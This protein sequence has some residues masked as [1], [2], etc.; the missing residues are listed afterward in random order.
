M[1]DLSNSDELAHYMA[2]LEEKRAEVWRG[3]QEKFRSLLSKAVENL[4]QA[5][6]S[7][8]L[9]ASIE[10]LKAVG[11]YGDGTMN[12]IGEQDPEKLIHQ[13]AESQGDGEGVLRN[14]LLAM[15][16]NLDNAAWRH[17]LAEME[18]EIRRAYLDGCIGVSTRPARGHTRMFRTATRAERRYPP[19]PTAPDHT[20]RLVTPRTILWRKRRV[21]SQC[22]RGKL[23]PLGSTPSSSTTRSRR[24]ALCCGGS[25]G[26]S[27]AEP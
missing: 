10:L 16:E 13:Q 6:E 25:A 1:A 27:L 4:G 3:V 9:K 24:P 18:T 11:I 19:M 26:R 17:R 12:V 15:A 20:S 22:G 23:P 14:A 5:V 7:G 8:D 2:A 21:T